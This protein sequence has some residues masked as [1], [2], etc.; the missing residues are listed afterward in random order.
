MHPIL[1]LKNAKY[2]LQLAE[3]A[4][5]EPVRKRYARMARA[6]LDQAVTEDWLDG[7]MI[8]PA[9]IAATD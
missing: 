5:N 2:C 7:K 6:W 4:E 9:P 1:A 3:K 8:P